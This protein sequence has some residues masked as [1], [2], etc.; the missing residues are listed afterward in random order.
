MSLFD[1]KKDK[2]TLVIHLNMKALEH[3]DKGGE[4]FRAGKLEEAQ[5]EF[6]EA[7]RLEPETSEAHFG[8]GMI[9]QQKG[10]L[11]EAAVSYRRA[12][13]ADPSN[14]NAMFNLGSIHIFQHD[15]E[16][17]INMFKLLSEL[18]PEDPQ[19]FLNLGSAYLSSGQSES[20]ISALEDALG[21]DP[22]YVKA[23]ILMAQAKQKRK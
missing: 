12:I 21:L 22:N 5:K 1:K 15:F 20:A 17:G 6:Q 10:L 19:V 9:S 2:G 11:D 14:T 3:A 13:Q 18:T 16:Q 23:Q 4:A 7:L 8:M